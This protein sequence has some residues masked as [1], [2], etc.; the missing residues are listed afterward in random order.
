MN[1]CV[2]RL[3]FFLFRI[4]FWYRWKM[5]N[6][7]QKGDEC[8]AFWLL[9]PL[10]PFGIS[11]I[12]WMIWCIWFLSSNCLLP[13]ILPA[14]E[15]ICFNVVWILNISFNIMHFNDC[16]LNRNSLRSVVYNNVT[17]PF[18]GIKDWSC[19]CI[20]ALVTSIRSFNLYFSGEKCKYMK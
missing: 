5:I 8:L 4:I 20:W 2:S 13:L 19:Y 6:E 14:V 11:D 15:Y 9:N 10:H 16:Y 7:A 17:Y 12:S 1:Y 18:Y 3:K